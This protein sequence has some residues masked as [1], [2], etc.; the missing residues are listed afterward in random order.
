M[1]IKRCKKMSKKPIF[2]T[3]H[4]NPD[5]DSI[6][7]AISYAYLKTQMGDEALPI[8]AG[9]ANK[10]TNFALDYFGVE[11]PMVVNDFYVKVSEVVEKIPAVDAAATMKDIALWK[12]EHAVNRVPVV[13]D[14]K[15]LGV[16]CPQ[17]LADAALA[18]LI[19]KENALTAGELVKHPGHHVVTDTT[20][21][22]DLR[23]QH[24]GY[25]AVM[26]KDGA[27]VGVVR[28]NVEMPKE[29]QRVI[30]TDHNEATQIIDGIEEAELIGTVDHHRISLSTDKPIFIHFE[31]VGCTCTIVANMFR[32]NNVEIPKYIAGMLLSAILSDTVEFRSP[33]CTPKDKETAEYLAKIAGVDLHEYA[34][35]MLKAGADVSDLTFEEIVRTDCKEFSSNNETISIAQISLMDTEDVLKHKKE[36][37]AALEALRK[38]NGYQASYL[39]VTSILAE[40]TDLLY[41]GDVDGI[42][43]KAFGKKPEDKSVFLANTMSR[44]KQIVPFLLDAMK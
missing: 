32:D 5:T 15:C 35:A 2:V 39:M 10:E 44:K 25:V 16:I 34:M 28:T 20:P 33:T 23:G 31:P 29:K 3:G 38:E 14:G 11:H 1:N 27:Y 22:H 18:T 8:C 42:V 26:D 6:C 36:L 43:E 9:K 13:K 4:K 37:V 30:L 21:I 24:C 41:A 19:G 7:S 40:S 12:Q 17:T